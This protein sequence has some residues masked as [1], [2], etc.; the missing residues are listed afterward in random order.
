[1]GETDGPR[2]VVVGAGFAGLRAVRRLASAGVHVLWVDGRNY[3]C[4]LPLL[5]Q[6]ATA[7]LEPQEIA[8]PARSILRRFPTAEFR[9]AHVVGGD[10]AA[11]T[12]VTADGERIAYDRLIIA[13]GGAAEDFGVAGAR[14]TAF[15][16]YDLEDARLLRNHVLRVLEK[17]EALEE[18]A[19]RSALLTFVIVG[20]GPTGVEMAGALAEFRTHVVPRDYRHVRA[21]AVRIVL[22][23]AGPEVLPPFTPRLRARARRDLIHRGVDVR[24]G[25]QV[26]RITPDGVELM[27]GETIAARTT[28]WAAGI[29]AAPVTAELGL[30]T[31]KSGRVRVDATL[32]VPGHPEVFAAGD[33]AVVDGAERLP[34]VAQVAI[35]QGEHAAAN[36]LRSLRGEPC[37][38]FAYRD[39]GSMATIGRSHAVAMIG[40]FQVAGRLA[41]WLWLAV[42]LVMLIGFRNRLVVLVNWAWSYVT[43]DFGLR[44]IVG[45]EPERVPG[46]A[47]A[48][49][50]ERRRSGLG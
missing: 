9:L 27:T 41:W 26:T 33:I 19:E 39:K 8:Y 44:A 46:N 29:R 2:V 23:E 50:V 13:A 34:Q 40:R 14:D 20:G 38:P 25:A 10:P 45:A 36:V 24:T 35:Q 28:I 21:D 43:Y 37:L 32:R 49:D 6:V 1:M 30:A 7:G 11:R 16:L 42:H 22:L 47:R 3:H 15:H 31:G 48:T 4:F 12:L 18:P 5:Y 17:A